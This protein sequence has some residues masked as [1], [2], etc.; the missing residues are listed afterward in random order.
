MTLTSDAAAAMTF[1]SSGFKE[2]YS[3]RGVDALTAQIVSALRAWEQ[4]AEFGSRQWADASSAPL[5]SRDVREAG[6]LTSGFRGYDMGSVDA[7]LDEVVTTLADY[8]ARN[9]IDVSP[10]APG[11]GPAQAAEPSPA[12]TADHLSR[13]IFP[14]TKFEG[15]R[16]EEVDAF[17]DTLTATPVSYTH[18]TLPT[19]P[20]V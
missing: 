17:M 5:T 4:G 1:A 16:R 3:R 7:F 13:T 10:A 11:T 2:G 8:E 15:Y 20:Y 12:V 19:T 18:L 9:G 14:S 6:I